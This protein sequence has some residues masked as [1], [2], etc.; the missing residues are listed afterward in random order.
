MDLLDSTED[1]FKRQITRQLKIEL[2]KDL[3]EK[4]YISL[5][6]NNENIGKSLEELKAIS[7]RAADVFID[8]ETTPI[9]G[10]PKYVFKKFETGK[11]VPFKTRRR[12]KMESRTRH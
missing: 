5:V 6:S 10:Y 8:S 3:S 12:I 11:L 7:I 1:A 2:R 4:L 9:S